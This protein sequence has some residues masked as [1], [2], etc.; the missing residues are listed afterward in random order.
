METELIKRARQYAEE[1][2]AHPEFKKYIYHNL[3]HTLEV[4]SAVDT[5]GNQSNL[6]EDELE[7][8][9]IAAWFH[10]IGYLSGGTNHEENGVQMAREVLTNWGTPSQK[11]KAVTDA[12]LSTR[13]PQQPESL[14]SNVLCDADLYHLATGRCQEKG[15]K[16]RA[17]MK[18]ISGKEMTD[19]EWIANTLAFME[20]HHYHTPYGKTILE[21]DKKKNSK[22]LRKQLEQQEQT[23]RLED[24]EGQLIKS[25][26]KVEKSKAIKRARGIEINL[27]NVLHNHLLLTGIAAGK[28]NTLIA[29]NAL[30]LM[31]TV[32]VF[33]FRP[34]ESSKLILP[35]LVLGSTS[36]IALILAMLATQPSVLKGRFEKGESDK[37][38]LSSL[39]FGGLYKLSFE[40]FEKAIKEV[41]KDR[42]ALK[43]SMLKDVHYLGKGLIKKSRYL[44]LSYYVFILGI[45]LAIATLVANELLN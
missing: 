2:F 17:E 42:E 4:V 26:Q 9:V 43:R 3:D 37:Q 28:A 35:T 5:I 14:V 36:L 11:I 23:Q 27:R 12:I 7:S 38:R 18:L 16:L 34:T 41:L 13:T 44:R 24:L 39:F 19:Q 31:M 25:Q 32:I 20:D 21:K 45:V 10:D 30:V 40:N 33:S 6:T 15:E 1:T 22:K 29:I 8:A